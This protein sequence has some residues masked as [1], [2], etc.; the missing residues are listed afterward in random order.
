M[1]RRRPNQMRPVALRPHVLVHPEGSVLAAYGDTQVLV[2]ASIDDRVPAWLAGRGSGWVDAEYGM[3]PRATHTRSPRDSQRPRP[4]GRALEI[5]RLVGRSLR[6]AV[7]LKRLGERTITIDCDVV[8]ADGGTRTAA[9]TGGYVALAVAIAHL[10]RR[11]PLPAGV[12]RGRV[13]A[14]AVGLVDGVAQVDLDYAMDSRAEVDLNVVMAG[15]GRL[16]E[17][18]G[19]GESGHFSTS[20]LVD[21]LALAEATR[22]G[23]EAAQDAAV[24]APFHHRGLG[25]DLVA[26]GEVAGPGG[27]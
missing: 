20:Q 19:T 2:A 7:D 18:Q 1:P 25:A 6:A 27:A 4:N 26:D 3:L 23:L 13:S 11:T 8:Q 16:V 24:G 12:L 14:V 9:I 22:P 21:M 10:G 17:I 15:D 5:G